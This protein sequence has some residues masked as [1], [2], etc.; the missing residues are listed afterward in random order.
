MG[1]PSI[2]T[3]A[4]LAVE[5][6]VAPHTFDVSSE[7]YEF[8]SESLGLEAT[9]TDNNAIRGTRSHEANTVREG[10]ETVSGDI[11]FHPSPADLDLWLPRILGAAE[12]LDS[13]T[14]A[15]TVPAFGVMID[16]VA[17]VFSYADCYVNQATFKSDSGGLLELTL[18]L[19]GVSESVG[20][21]GTFPAISLATAAN[22]VP[23][24]HE[25]TSGAVTLV[26]SAR[27]TS[28]IEIVINNNLEAKFFN[29]QTATHVIAKDRVITVKTTHPY[30]STDTD[31]YAQAVAG[32]AGSIVYTNGGMSTTFT[33]GNLKVP[34]TSPKI[35]GKDEITIEL[36]MTAFKTG[37][38]DELVVTHDSVA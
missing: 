24:T 30:S 37:S 36:E 22:N 9:H 4:R 11:T 3:Q 13:F 16:R 35:P 2:G 27:D 32:A 5:P 15:E 18:N 14:L 25:D 28:S 38:T 23:Y 21:A 8:I 19:I 33:F 7:T 17:K 12:S 1:T 10:T 6:G 29:S 20:N 34:D 26:G 31:L